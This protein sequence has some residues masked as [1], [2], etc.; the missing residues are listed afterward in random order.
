MRCS[1]YQ[2]ALD[3]L[4]AL[5]EDALCENLTTENA[6]NVLILADMHSVDQLKAMAIDFINR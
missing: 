2:Y 3:G 5:C 4:K 1:Y 6:A